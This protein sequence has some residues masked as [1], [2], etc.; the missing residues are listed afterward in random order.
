MSIFDFIGIYERYE[1]D[2]QRLGKILGRNFVSKRRN[3][4]PHELYEQVEGGTL[5]DGEL[6][7]RIACNLE[8]DIAFYQK[9]VNSF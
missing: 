7:D 6:L 8:D 4:N 3:A 2:L 5:I 9:I 1:D